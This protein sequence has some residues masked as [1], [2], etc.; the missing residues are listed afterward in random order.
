MAVFPGVALRALAATV[1]TCAFVLG[2]TR[3]GADAPAIVVSGA[4]SARYARLD[5]R[6]A[7]YMQ[8]N[9]VPDAEL[10]ISVRGQVR[11]SHA[12]TNGALS[13]EPITPKSLFR[14]A[15]NSKA[16]TCAAITQLIADG[17]LTGREPVFAYLGIHDPLPAGSSVA[18]PR[19]FSITVREL[20]DHTGGWDRS[21]ARFDPVHAMRRIAI[22]SGLDHPVS[23]EEVARYMLGQPLQHAPGT[24]Y[25]YSNLG[26]LLLGL[27]IEKASGEPYLTYVQTHIAQPLGVND[28]VLSPTEDP[29]APGE[30]DTYAS[31]E[32]GPSPLHLAD[33]QPVP[34]YAG[35]DGEIRE[36]SVAA[37]GLATS[38]E[39]MLALMS[40][41]AIWGLGPPLAAG[42]AAREGAADGSNTYAKQRADGMAYVILVN[43]HNEEAFHALE[44]QIDRDL[45]ATR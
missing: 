40:A 24:T 6:I 3:A 21:A 17:A 4:R 18:D 20:V 1:L 38:A 8:T 31:S 29:R 45:D 10:A 43:R 9:A 26:Y 14:L 2:A 12:Y 16:W 5:A 13:S 37:G 34:G 30:V 7:S 33:T 42:S 28:L 22:D 35:G 32:R 39:S 23:A 11:L 19:V 25:A 41:H 27:V 36:V 15:S 44:K